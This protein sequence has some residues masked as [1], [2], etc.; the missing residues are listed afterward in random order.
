ME[1]YFKILENKDF[2]ELVNNLTYT[3]SKKYNHKTK[4]TIR[5][6]NISSC[7]DI[8]VSS[9]YDSKGFKVGLPYFWSFGVET[10]LTYGR[11]MQEFIDL[12]EQ[13]TIS[14][15]IVIYIHNLGYEFQF[16]RSYLNVESIFAREER[17]PFKVLSAEIEFRDSLILSGFNLELT[18]KNLVKR[19]VKKLVGNLDY[20][21]IRTPTTPLKQDE[22]DY[23]FND[24][25]I[26]IC[27]IWEQIEQYGNIIKI[28]MTNTGR[29][30]LYC[31]SK[32]LNKNKKYRDLISNLKLTTEEYK[33]L[34]HSFMGGFTHANYKEV[35]KVH[36]NVS[37]YDITSSY[38]F[39]LLTE[40][41]PMSAGERIKITSREHF[42]EL[43]KEHCIVFTVCFKGLLQKATVYDSYLSASKCTFENGLENNGRLISAD[44]C[45]CTITEIDFDIIVQCYD[46][47]EVVFGGGYIYKKGYLPKQFLQCILDFY[48]DKTTLKNVVGMESEYLL[49]KGM[50]NSTYGMTV[51]D[52]INDIIDFDS[53]WFTELV[54][55]VDEIDKYNNSKNR[56]LFY[57]WGVYCTAYARRNLWYGIF[58]LGTDYIYSDTDS[59]KFK[60]EHSDIFEEYNLRV[61]NKIRA[62]QE[63]Y[64][65]DIE[66]FKPLTVK[67]E[68][69]T[70]GVY[71]Q[72]EPYSKFKTLGAKRY[73]VQYADGHLSI[74]C[75]GLNKGK[76][77]QYLESFENPFE[78]FNDYMCI[79][80]ENAGR[81][82]VTYIDE[83]REGVISDY[84]G[85]EYKYEVPTGIHIEQSDYHLELGDKYKK[86]LG[87]M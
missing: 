14:D 24:V 76:T 19:K 48:R 83:K 65:F 6:A 81:N 42:E 51:T 26:V 56:F 13:I 16:L 25:K 18:A 60:G 20:S 38:P 52:I 9:F 77:S 50:L 17:K 57:P 11:T 43:R 72:E 62:V 63:K 4:E 35:L 2:I 55:D 78:V 31:K 58:K 69:K 1:D 8:E 32:C 47:E 68:Q 15:R 27:Y 54:I 10:Y 37:S 71:E 36:D 45:Y 5:Y 46:F 33:M 53:D 82:I 21:K 28:P 79:P 70:I 34:K 12:L 30:R 61:E 75:S 23:C 7:F 80:K 44:V 64:S 49:K 67:G 87:I 3:V 41:Y 85:V 74:T 86:L 66:D 59:L 40:Y 29:V 73:L 39:V 84:L 22:L